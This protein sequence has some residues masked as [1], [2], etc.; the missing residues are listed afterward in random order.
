MSALPPKA[1]LSATKLVDVPGNLRVV[2]GCNI[3]PPAVVS[4]RTDCSDVRFVPK[5]DIHELW[6]GAA[7]E[8]GAHLSDL[9]I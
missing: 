4:G 7:D 1:G 5:A 2:A 6:M 9:L 8:G 3:A